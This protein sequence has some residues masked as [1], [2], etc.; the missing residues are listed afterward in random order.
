MKL[1]SFR[2]SVPGTSS[3]DRY[4]FPII[5]QSQNIFILLI[6]FKTINPFFAPSCIQ[7]GGKLYGFRLPLWSPV[8]TER[9]WYAQGKTQLVPGRRAVAEADPSTWHRAPKSL[10][11]CTCGGWSR[12]SPTRPSWVLHLATPLQDRQG[13]AHLAQTLGSN[14][15]N[16][17][18]F[19]FSFFFFFW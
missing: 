17:L 14:L 13:E 11:I 10:R 2:S 4:L 1:Q 12:R 16:F 3:T 19:P 6:S 8:H 7:L 5:S 15:N 18:I 9:H